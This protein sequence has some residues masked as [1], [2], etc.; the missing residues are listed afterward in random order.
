VEGRRLSV[1]TEGGYTPAGAG[2]TVIEVHGGRVVVREAAP[3]PG[4]GR[5]QDASSQ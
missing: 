5:D 1:V 2:V 4:A 3:A